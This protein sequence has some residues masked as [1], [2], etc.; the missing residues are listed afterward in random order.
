MLTNKI[1]SLMIM[2]HIHTFE[3]FLNEGNISMYKS[4]VVNALK[5]L[6]YKVK[7]SDLKIGTKKESGYDIITLNGESL[8][9]SSDYAQMVSWIQN[10]VKDNPEKYGLDPKVLES[11]NEAND[12]SY[13]K[14]YAEGSN[15]SPKWYSNEITS[16]LGVAKLVKS[17]IDRELEEMDDKD[18]DIDPEDEKKLNKLAMDYFKQFKSINGN[19]VSAMLFQESK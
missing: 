17:V 18:A 2:K 15:Q 13:W 5:Q 14:D 3:N 9:S 19:I 12:L 8:C 11:A 16:S 7:Q 10:A 6:G 1:K 4:T